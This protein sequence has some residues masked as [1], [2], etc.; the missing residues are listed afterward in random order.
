MSELLKLA[1][2][3][4]KYM[5]SGM[6]AVV[7]M[8]LGVVADLAIP[9]LLRRLVDQGITQKNMSV[10]LTTALIMLARAHWF[11]SDEAQPTT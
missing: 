2:F 3:G 10:V 6:F 7:L 8:T 4:K 5:A 11:A 1:K 9:A